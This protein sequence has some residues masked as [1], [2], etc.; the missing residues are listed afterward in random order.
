M[1][2][3]G[4]QK[5][6]RQG[7][8]RQRRLRLT[9]RSSALWWSEPGY[10][11]GYVTAALVAS[12][13]QVRALEAYDAAGRCVLR[14]RREQTGAPWCAVIAENEAVTGCGEHAEDRLDVVSGDS[15]GHEIYR[16]RERPLG[17]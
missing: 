12:E 9:A 2:G 3:R 17:R 13:S 16:V 11:L 8:A 5:E 10:R 7:R 1:S 4:D 15:S 14:A 6:N